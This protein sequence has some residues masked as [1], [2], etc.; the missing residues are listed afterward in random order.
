[1]TPYRWHRTPW[2]LAGIFIFWLGTGAPALADTALFEQKQCGA[3]HRLSAEEPAESHPAPDLFYAG[4]KYKKAWL[5]EFLQKPEPIRKAGHPRDPGFLKGE[6]E[7]KGP[8]VAVT[9]KEAQ[10]LGAFLMT[11]AL[12]GLE[13]LTLDLKPLA[14]GERVRAKM[15]FERDHSCIAC[16]ESYNLARQPRG[17]VSGPSLLDA[18]NRLQT[19][20]V[21][22]WLK[23][24][25]RFVE[26][27]RMPVYDL[28]E[29][30]LKLMTR[31][32]LSHKKDEP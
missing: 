13:P 28:E 14:R 9:K 27:S 8:H 23:N 4:D 12:D 20:W 15:L 18:G 21:Y 6:P 10:T 29:T 7:H 1:M 2:T 3:C 5:V 24:P 11:Q 22:R 31:Y 19:E 32:V 16:H 25:K 26:K 17:G 30:E